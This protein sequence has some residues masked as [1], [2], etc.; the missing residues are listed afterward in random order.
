CPNN[1]AGCSISIRCITCSRHFVRRSIQ[2]GS[3]GQRHLQRQRPS[4]WRPWPSVGGFFPERRM[5][6]RTESELLIMES[7]EQA[8][9]ETVIRLE[10][11]SVAY[12][13]PRERIRSFK[14][15]AIRLLKG[16]VKFQE[17]RALRDV[18]IEIRQ[19]EVFGIVG[20]NGAGKSTML[21]VVSR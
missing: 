21:K 11:V 17:F 9:R 7:T 18:N 19:G 6:L 4:R 15:Y 8:E 20:H 10:N 14:E 5:N 13:A 16:E 12:R 1:G 2:A 3:P